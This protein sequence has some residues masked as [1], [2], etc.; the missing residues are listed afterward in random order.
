M[1][2]SYKFLN[3]VILKKMFIHTW[4]IVT[5]GRQLNVAVYSSVLQAFLWELT[6]CAR[7]WYR[8]WVEWCLKHTRALCGS[9]GAQAAGLGQYATDH[10]YP[11]MPWRVFDAMGKVLELS[12]T[13]PF[14]PWTQAAI[15]AY[16]KRKSPALGQWATERL[17]TCSAH[18]GH[19]NFA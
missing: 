2:R 12:G 11:A 16:P 1:E 6:V 7:P 4:K 18:T 14:P 10:V 8:W 13:Q 3:S 19:T 15:I 17:L 9:W 5:C